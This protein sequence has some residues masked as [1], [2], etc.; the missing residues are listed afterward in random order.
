VTQLLFAV[1]SKLFACKFVYLPYRLDL[2][3]TYQFSPWSLPNPSPTFPSLGCLSVFISCCCPTWPDLMLIFHLI[4][5]LV[6]ARCAWTW[7]GVSCSVVSSKWVVFP[8]A[9]FWSLDCFR[10]ASKPCDYLCLLSLL[11]MV[12]IRTTQS[13]PLEIPHR[14]YVR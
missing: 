7:A 5:T 13:K 12:L 9:M 10:V 3:L 14:A 2:W 4:I 11:C 1:T 8:C 6:D